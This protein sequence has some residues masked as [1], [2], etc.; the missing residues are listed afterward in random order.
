MMSLKNGFCFCMPNIRKHASASIEI[1]H[2]KISETLRLARATSS[3]IAPQQLGSVL[4]F[5]ISLQSNNRRLRMAKS[6]LSR[7][8]D[9]KH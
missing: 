4:C 1:S 8:C 9:L 2:H 6:A 7:S 3:Q 5:L